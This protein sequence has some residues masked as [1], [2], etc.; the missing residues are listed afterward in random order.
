MTVGDVEPAI[1]SSPFVSPDSSS[2]ESSRPAV[3]PVASATPQAPLGSAVHGR[4]T[5]A[6]AHGQTASMDPAAHL[7]HISTS[8]EC[9][10]WAQLLCADASIPVSAVNTAAAAAAS[11]VPEA[12]VLLAASAI[13]APAVQVAASASV[14][15][16]AGMLGAAPGGPIEAP[17]VN[18]AAAATAAPP[19]S[20]AALP[21]PEAQF[22]VAF[23]GAHAPTMDAAAAAAPLAPA[24]VEAPAALGMQGPPVNAAA[25]AGQAVVLGDAD[26]HVIAAAAQVV[27]AHGQHIPQA[28]AAAVA[29]QAGLVLPNAAAPAQVADLALPKETMVNPTGTGPVPFVIRRH[30]T[31]VC[32]V[33]LSEQHQQTGTGHAPGRHAVPSLQDMARAVCISSLIERP[34]PG[35]LLSDLRPWMN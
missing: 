14:V 1:T 27:P 7:T 20:A 24:A 18:A 10:G 16:E 25:A 13:Q 26:M 11:V 33:K 31:G 15:P 5:A 12:G 22:A 35:D 32:G 29:P 6:A 28:N 17:A 34:K 8:A 4:G 30:A 3:V 19:A 23:S 9:E 2:V 21:A